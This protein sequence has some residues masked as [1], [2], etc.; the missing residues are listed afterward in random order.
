MRTLLEK[1]LAILAKLFLWRYHPKI[2]AITGSVGKTSTKEACLRVLQTKYSVRQSRGNYNNEI[3]L[4]LTIAGEQTGGR[5]LLRW[6][7]IF[8]KSIA[9]LA[10]ADYPQVLVLELGVDRPGNI[11][12]LMKILGKV[13]VAVVTDIGISHLQFFT[14]Q[15]ELAREKLSL[16]K[17]L[18]LEAAAV[19]NFDSPK[20]QEGRIQTKA[21]VVSFGFAREAQIKASDFRLMQVEGTWGS[22]FKV[23]YEGTVL[24]FFLPNSLGKPA[25]YAA[26][27][28]VAVGLQFDINL[29]EASEALKSY[30]P[31]QGR[32][33]LIAGIRQTA[34]IDDTYNA[35]PASTIAA[36]DTLN[37]LALGRK[38]AVLGS[39]TELG[40]QTR[41]GHIDVAA[42]I[43]ESA[44][45]LVYLVGEEAKIIREGLQARKF[46]GRAQWFATSD[47]AK[48]SVRSALLPGDTILVK[49][50]QAA[51][52][53]KI[54]KE[55]M[56]E[57]N[58][59]PQ[60]LVRQSE[61]WL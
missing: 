5:N 25:V 47:S 3:G 57:P 18:P 54:V 29:V 40:A 30:E 39:M 14:D 31:S 60:L 23:H 32:Q 44:I 38:I 12:Y 37:N 13:D 43:V 33:R 8:L 9:K 50:S 56:L 58:L 1:N 17:K 34:I 55:I 24:P 28:A 20:V 51:R 19:L 35:A 7:W 59:A 42:K 49:G 52:M 26:L 45:G 2:V 15:S 48:I 6:A 21:K 10:H 53:E 41:S 27:A 36:L 61:S 16:I 11:A 46:S 22:N 4:P